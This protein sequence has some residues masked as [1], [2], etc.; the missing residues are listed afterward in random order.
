[1]YACMPIRAELNGQTLQECIC[2]RT[3]HVLNLEDDA[4]IVLVIRILFCF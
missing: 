1:M 4:S 2:S 3:D